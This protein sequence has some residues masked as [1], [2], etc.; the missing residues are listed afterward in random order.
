MHNIRTTQLLE[1]FSLHAELSAHI[2]PAELTPWT[3]RLVAAIEADDEGKLE[4]VIISM[5]VEL[6][7]HREYSA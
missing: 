4:L 5:D 3:I 6:V 2:G 1:S 7:R